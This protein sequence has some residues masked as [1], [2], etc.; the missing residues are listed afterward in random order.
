M[1]TLLEKARELED[2]D[3]DQITDEEIELALAFLFGEVTSQQVSVVMGIRSNS[4][5]RV[6]AV[7]RIFKAAREGKI[8]RI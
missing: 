7:S 3:S 2:E 5:T 6:W 4:N 1:V 8:K